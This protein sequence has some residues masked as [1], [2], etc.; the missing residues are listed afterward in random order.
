MT[1]TA[2]IAGGTAP[3]TLT[4]LGLPNPGCTGIS[5]PSVKCSVSAPGVWH[6]NLSVQDAAG[7]TV[8]SNL[9]LVVNA[10]AAPAS[11]SSGDVAIIVGVI[12]VIAVAAVTVVAV[13][14]HGRKAPL[15]PTSASPPS[16]R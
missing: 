13:V 16:A 6:V 11:L 2:N 12:V 9:T 15:R 10:T 14:L 8:Y 5:T 7:A 4:Y 3:L 1:F